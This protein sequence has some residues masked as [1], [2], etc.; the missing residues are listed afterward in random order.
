MSSYE[1][2]ER[3]PFYP[4]S[5]PSISHPPLPSQIPAVTPQ[6]NTSPTISDIQ[7]EN[8]DLQN[9]KRL[10]NKARKIGD[11]DT[12]FSLEDMYVELLRIPEKHHAPL[13]PR[14]EIEASY[15]RVLREGLELLEKRRK[16]Q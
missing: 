3:S 10:I 14:S 7:K 1:A 2:P 8:A 5:P 4:A 16:L 15:Q 12:A 13:P 6:Q 9:V 11:Y